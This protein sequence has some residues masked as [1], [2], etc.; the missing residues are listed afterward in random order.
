MFMK[1]NFAGRILQV[2]EA[3]DYGDAVSRQACEIEEMLHRMGYSTGIYSRWHHQKMEHARSDLEELQV[4]DRDIVIFHFS[5]FS[6][7]VL[8]FLQR[9]RCTKV[10]VYHNITPPSFFKA[11]TGI[12]EHCRKGIEQLPDIIKSFHFFWGDSAY[13]IEQLVNAG[14]RREKCAVVPIIVE[15]APRDLEPRLER[16]QGTWMFLGRV[17]A[18]K[19]HIKL[20]ELFA[21]VRA[22]SAE[23]AERF[24]LVGGFQDDDAYYVELVRRIGELNLQKHVVI[25]GK[26]TDAKVAEHFARSSIYVSM[27]EHEGFGVPLIEA[28]LADLPVVALNNTAVGETMGAGQGAVYSTSELKDLIKRIL[29]DPAERSRVLMEQK[30]NA[31]RFS[32]YSVEGALESALAHILPGRDFD[33]KVSVVICTYNRRDLLDRCLDYLQ[34]QTNQNFEVV[35]VDGPSTDGTEAVLARYNE[36]IKIGRNPERNLSKSRNLG[37]ELASGSIIAFID[38]DALP[39]D[40]WIDTLIREFSTSPLTLA[41][42]G[43]PVYYAGTLK[44]QAEDIGINRFAEAKPNID[45]ADIGSNGWER[46]LLG[47]NACFRAS[48][49]HDAMGFDEQFDY[50]LDESELSFRL[51]RNNLV[52][53]YCADLFLR[54]EFAQSHNRGGKYKYNWFTICKNTAYFIAAYSGYSGDALSQFVARRILEERIKPLEAG[55]AAGEVSSDEL[56]QY[57]EAINAGVQQGLAD[58]EGFPRTRKLAET[59]TPFLPFTRAAAYPLL[60]RDLN[61]LHICIVSKEF[62][63]FGASGGIGTLYYHLA[64][65]LL[66][67][68]HEVTV[69]TPADEA[70]DYIQGRFAVRYV[71]RE[72]AV[73]D[74]DANPAAAFVDNLN[75]SVSALAAI[76][77]L[78][79]EK[80]V[81]VVDSALWDSE[82]LAF[83]L[84]EHD[85]RPPLVVRLVTPFPVAEKLNGWSIPDR[86]RD[87]LRAAEQS[88]IA[89]A[90]A[91]VPISESIAGTIENEYGISRDERWHHSHC[92]MAYWTFF[93]SQH[94]YTDLPSTTGKPFPVPPGA[95]LVLF[96]GRLE[97]RKGVDLLLNAANEFLAADGEAHLLLAGRDIENWTGRSQDIL[98]KSILN[99]VHFFGEVSD[100]TREKL[101]HAAYC[102]VFPSRYESFGLVPLEAF[103]HGVPVVAS[104]AGAIPE[105]VSDGRSG[106]LFDSGNA[107][108]LAS[109]VTLL[110]SQNELRARLSEGAKRQSKKFSSRKTAIQAIEIYSQLLRP[111]SA[112]G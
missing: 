24:Y 39:F 90:D 108:A 107:Q 74:L 96:V 79:D 53:G 20:V 34:Y 67:M 80:P 29:R 42:L 109:K 68:G 97:S 102:L 91:V 86:D 77:E 30:K 35:V 84:L 105:V 65:E 41:G 69:I 99:R 110:L 33:A 31:L 9:F 48:A 18:N 43:G 66:L 4:T 10:C 46:S 111:R 63:P 100:A 88:L 32:R 95:K 28:A 82:C 55:F 101:L 58:A 61:R 49:L 51:Q 60:G 19:A 71:K 85:A 72:R 52:V 38:D 112:A 26:V 54:H 57:V 13:N 6:E 1:S 103:T 92:G 93:D 22:E 98:A 12:Y 56:T 23:L 36:R 15:R 40:D 27:S 78:H 14:A 94:G 37:I 59:K 64:S 81:D 17:A 62:P 16:Q 8:P 25:T 104:N 76:A 75:W 106:L 7:Y 47:T 45:S 70:G 73:S 50:F 3:L 21:E 89:N 44:Y 83:S 2:I 5:G 11:G 87:L